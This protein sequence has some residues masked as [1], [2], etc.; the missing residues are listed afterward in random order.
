[1]EFKLFGPLVVSRPDAM[2][3]V[4]V[5][6]DVVAENMDAQAYI[7]LVGIPQCTINQYNECPITETTRR[8]ARILIG[9]EIEQHSSGDYVIG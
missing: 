2:G 7:S 4:A 6:F 3:H 9:M 5:T 1:M 8:D